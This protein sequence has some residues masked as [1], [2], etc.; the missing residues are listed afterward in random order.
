MIFEVTNTG[1]AKDT[2]MC[3]RQ[4][5]ILHDPFQ[6]QQL[7][8]DEP[9]LG[10]ASWS[11]AFKTMFLNSSLTILKLKWQTYRTGDQNEKALRKRPNLSHPCD[12]VPNQKVAHAYVAMPSWK[13]CI[14]RPSYLKQIHSCHPE[15]QNAIFS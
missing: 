6:G 4:S 11:N 1:P 12:A 14:R 9:P 10:E 13:V 2:V 5:I 7:R 3:A 15:V 8:D